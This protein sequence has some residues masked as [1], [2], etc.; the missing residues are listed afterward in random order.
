MS[1]DVRP[2]FVSDAFGTLDAPAVYRLM[3]TTMPMVY[4]HVATVLTTIASPSTTVA[5]STTPTTSAAAS[6]AGLSEQSVAEAWSTFNGYSLLTLPSSEIALRRQIVNDMKSSSTVTQLTDD[7]DAAGIWLLFGQRT[8]ILPSP[9][10]SSTHRLT[11]LSDDIASYDRVL[12]ATLQVRE[13]VTGVTLA[14]TLF[15]ANGHAGSMT[16][17]H[18]LMRYTGST[19]TKADN[20]ATDKKG[21][22]AVEEFA[23]VR[24]SNA[25]SAC[26]LG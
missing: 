6:R 21:F 15:M 5:S 17:E 10:P 1:H 18:D 24:Y 25:R 13:S 3:R 20:A 2:L 11:P 19:D 16:N 8:N 12:H 23:D 9:L 26:L 14:R 7:G 4:R 22:E